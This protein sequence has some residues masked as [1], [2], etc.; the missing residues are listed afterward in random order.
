MLTL[1]A[2]RQTVLEIWD[3]AAQISFGAVWNAKICSE[4][5]ACTVYPRRNHVLHLVD[6]AGAPASELLHRRTP[7]LRLKRIYT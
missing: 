7:G 3:Y 5:C 1:I 4:D 2:S 6:G